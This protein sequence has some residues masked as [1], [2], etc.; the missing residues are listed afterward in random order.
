MHGLSVYQTIQKLDKITHFISHIQ[1]LEINSHHE[2]LSLT[3]LFSS[4]PFI[5]MMKIVKNP[6]ICLKES[7][8]NVSS[9]WTTGHCLSGQ[10]SWTI[11]C[12]TEVKY[13]VTHR[14][15]SSRCVTMKRG[16]MILI[17]F[18]CW[19]LY[20]FVFDYF[21]HNDEWNGREQTCKT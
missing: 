13:R 5:I 15:K 10:L 12:V 16:L 9:N 14:N 2:Y 20:S 4:I 11:I 3:C 17:C 6:K 1:S 8:G 19:N 18:N 7:S 21:R